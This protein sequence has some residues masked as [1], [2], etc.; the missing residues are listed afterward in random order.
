MIIPVFS[1]ATATTWFFQQIVSAGLKVTLV[2]DGYEPSDSYDL[3]S[4]IPA[5]LKAGSTTTLAGTL[6]VGTFEDRP[7]IRTDAVT[8]VASVTAGGDVIGVVVSFTDGGNQRILVSILARADQ[9]LI[10]IVPDGTSITVHWAG[11]D[12]T[13]RV[14]IG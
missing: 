14:L 11:G 5:P 7:V 12:A 10:G 6:T 2:R 3:V 1:H 13:G 8:T 4:D 9:T